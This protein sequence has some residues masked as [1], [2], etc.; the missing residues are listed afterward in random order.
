MPDLSHILKR[1][2]AIRVPYPVRYT[3]FFI[4]LGGLCLSLLVLLAG[5]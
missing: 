1:I 3:T 5:E 4:S 2:D